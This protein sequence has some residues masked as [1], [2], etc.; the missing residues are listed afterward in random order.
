[1]ALAR[2]GETPE[3]VTLLRLRPGAEWAHCWAE[4]ETLYAELKGAQ[5]RLSGWALPVKLDTAVIPTTR[6][7]A[8][9]VRQHQ[10]D[11]ILVPDY[12][13]LGSATTAEELVQKIGK[14]TRCQT[15]VL[16]GI[17]A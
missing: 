11:L 13:R 17:S 4:E 8:Q 15:Q 7:L 6:A 14:Y 3:Q 12:A 9:Y 1:M 2:V 5:A 16:P 10:I